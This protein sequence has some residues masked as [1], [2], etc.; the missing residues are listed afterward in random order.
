ML[1]TSSNISSN[2]RSRAAKQFEDLLNVRK[3]S[4][5]IIWSINA[6]ILHKRLNTYVTGVLATENF[7]LPLISARMVCPTIDLIT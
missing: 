2:S 5:G 1:L 6:L 4:A 7:V 3:V